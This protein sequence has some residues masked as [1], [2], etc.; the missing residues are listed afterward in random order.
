M[1]AQAEGGE[2]AKTR[3]L[4]DSLLVETEISSSVT[5]MPERFKGCYIVDTHEG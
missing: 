5:R 1:L 3:H 4:D 2:L